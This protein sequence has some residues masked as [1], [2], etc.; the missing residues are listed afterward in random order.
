MSI[1]SKC[2]RIYAIN[3]LRHIIV[4]VLSFKCLVLSTSMTLQCKLSED[5]EFYCQHEMK[6]ESFIKM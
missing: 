3:S 5:V 4:S 2:H 1:S 6:I